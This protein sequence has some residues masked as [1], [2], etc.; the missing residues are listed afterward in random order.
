MNYCTI[1]RRPNSRSLVR[2]RHE[3][4]NLQYNIP[5]HLIPFGVGG[6]F[7]CPSTSLGQAPVLRRLLI[8][9]DVQFYYLVFRF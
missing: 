9:L 8:G 6:D 2:Y 4:T 7:D 3:Q 1:Y 5:Y